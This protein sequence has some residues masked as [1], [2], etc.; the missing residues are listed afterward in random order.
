MASRELPKGSVLTQSP[1]SAGSLSAQEEAIVWRAPSR[2]APSGKATAHFAADRGSD[3]TQADATE[4][5]AFARAS[6]SGSWPR[7]W[8]ASSGAAWAQPLMALA[9]ALSFVAPV[10]RPLAHSIA[11][12]GSSEAHW[13]RTESRKFCCSGPWGMA[14]PNFNALAASCCTH[15]EE[16]FCSAVVRALPSG[17]CLTQA[18]AACTSELAH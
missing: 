16:M 10:G 8:A 13:F 5:T 6:P 17:N 2:M 15:V 1:A 18:S 7:N 12:R 14:S 3:C 11:E 4:A 9:R